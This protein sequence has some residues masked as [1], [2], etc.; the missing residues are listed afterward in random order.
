[1]TRVFVKTGAFGWLALA[2]LLT[3]AIPAVTSGETLETQMLTQVNAVRTEN[4]LSRLR[5]DPRLASA[6][7]M[8][9]EDMAEHGFLGHQGSNGS[10]LGERTRD[11]GYRF[12]SVAENLA[13]GS[14]APKLVVA[15]WERSP[16]HRRNLINPEFDDAGIGY[17]HRPQD[18]QDGFR[19]YWSLVLGRA[20]DTGS[21]PA[22]DLSDR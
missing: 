1:M 19:H 11:A 14:L 5:L 7:R 10:T 18:K 3:I 6:A 22:G 12:R 21:S 17:A 16:G 20:L 4:G 2:L 15:D 9:A 13:A 8:Q